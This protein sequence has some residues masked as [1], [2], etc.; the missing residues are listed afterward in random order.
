MAN[1]VVEL[2]AVIH[3][4]RRVANTAAPI[5][6]S[7]PLQFDGPQPQFYGAQA[8]H[9]ATLE[10][11][12]FVGDVNRGGSVNCARYSLTPHCNGTHTECIGHITREPHYVHKIA[13]RHL[14]AAV[15]LS[16][17]PVAADST[18]EG[19]DPAPQAG[20]RLLTR[21]SL[22]QAARSHP[23]VAGGALVVRT[24]PND[25]SKLTRDYDRLVP[26]YFTGPAMHWIVQ[27]G[28]EH[29]IVDVPSLDRSADGG[30]L[31]SHR[32]FWGVPPGA[33]TA[34]AATRA[35]CTVTEL[36]Y[37]DSSTPD[38]TYLLNLQVAPFNA[39]AAPS[40]PVLYPLLPT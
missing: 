37:V 12:G 26:P 15:L 36:A 40:R 32:I 11:G 6:L 24:L 25:E 5:D 34:E 4:R 14:V 20:D 23:L 1:E 18:S 10:A 39:D 13:Q 31:T 33:T 35:H 21:D 22:Q 9:A 19:S 27:N 30:R 3:G 28:I 16:V 7:I 8:A 2:A 29:L 17:T 38:G